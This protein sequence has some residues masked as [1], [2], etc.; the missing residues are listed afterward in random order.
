MSSNWTKA[1]K[2]PNPRRYESVWKYIVPT[3]NVPPAITKW[4]HWASHWRTTTPSASYAFMVVFS[5]PRRA[6]QC[7][8]DIQ[9][10]MAAHNESAEEPVRVRIGLHTGETVQE[11]E[12]FYGRHVNLTSRIANA[13]EGGEILVS[14]LLRELTES[15]GDIAFGGERDVELKG[16]GEQRVFAVGWSS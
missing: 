13:A 9:R 4:T 11:A 6:L 1:S 16:L 7:A 5:N 12:D 14:S 2:P 15:A 3:R 8:I 10:A